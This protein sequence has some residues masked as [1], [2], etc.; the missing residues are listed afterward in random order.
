MI[1]DMLCEKCKEREAKY[2]SPGNWCEICWITWW[3]E[4]LEP[5]TDEHRQ[6]CLEDATE[7]LERNMDVSDLPEGE[8]RAAIE[9]AARKAVPGL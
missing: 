7:W 6:A 8:R 9:A 3:I 4:G 5:E 2:D 1:K